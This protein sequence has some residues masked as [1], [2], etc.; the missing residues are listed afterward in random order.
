[1]LQYLMVK[2]EIAD[3]SLLSQQRMGFDFSDNLWYALVDGGLE[4]LIGIT[5]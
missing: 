2:I 1:Y 3:C 4:D 5:F